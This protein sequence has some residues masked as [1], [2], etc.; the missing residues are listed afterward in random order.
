MRSATTDDIYIETSPDEV[1][2]ALL[3]AGANASWW[4]KARVRA[5]GTTIH[6]RARVAPLRPPVRFRATV[7]TVRPG[8]G[9]VWHIA[10]REVRGTAEV[11]LEPFKD[12]TIVHHVVDIERAGVR[13][14]SSVAR[15]HRWALRRGLNGLKGA[16]ERDGNRVARA[17]T[18]P[19]SAQEVRRS[20]R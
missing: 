19:R 10:G 11:W 15:R 6:V 13:R 20:A 8:Q 5:D 3:Q 17:L 7:G 14:L 12:G 16:L 18:S 4:P 2:R 1:H 9:F